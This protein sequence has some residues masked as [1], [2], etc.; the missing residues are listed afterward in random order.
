[1]KQNDK[2][3][4]IVSFLLI[5][6][7][8]II[9][10]GRAFY[11][12]VIGRDELTKRLNKQVLRV[13]K[14]FPYRGSIYDRNG[15]PLAINIQTYT[16]VTIPRLVKDK[17]KTYKKV[18][19][20]V[21]QL[22]Y[23]KI[24]RKIKNR[25][26][27]TFLARKVKLTEEQYLKIKKFEK[28]GIYID[29]V[30]K[31]YYPNN[32]LLA[33]T[34]G[35][36]GSENRGLG[37]IEALFDK[38]LRGKERIIKYIRDAK[39]RPIKFES[40]D[41]EGEAADIHLTI[42]KELQATAEKHLKEAIEKY[43]AT[44]GG[45]GV[46]DSR[47]G[48][49][50]ALA[51]Y[52]TFDPNKYNKSAPEYR[53]LAFVSD[54]F[55][56][57]STF[58][59]LTVASALEHKIARPDTN[60]YCERGAF[61][62]EDH[63]INEAESEKKYEWLSVSEILQFS[64]NIGT[65]KIA[66]DLTYPKLKTTLD[67]F[68]IGKKTKIEIPAESRGIYP[69]GSNVRPLTLSTISFGQGIATTGIQLLAAY[70]AI[71]N[72]G[73]YLPPTVIKGKNTGVEGKR[74]ISKQTAAELTEML[75]KTVEHGT[76]T[77]VKTPYFKIAGK[78]ST[79]QRPASTGGYKGYVPGF[80]GFPLNVDNKFVIYVYVDNPQGN[81]Y[82]GASVAG[83]VFKKVTQYL[84]YKNKDFRKVVV[85]KTKSKKTVS[86][87]RFNKKKIKRS[88]GKGFTPNFLGLDKISSG[89]LAAKHKLKVIHKG[90]GV[91]RE[92]KPKAGTVLKSKKVIK[93]Y[94]RPPTYE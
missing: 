7:F 39:G 32:E 40:Q 56:P 13:S 31:R 53:K 45:I 12:Q 75:V 5:C 92:Q 89:K 71:V 28:N 25:K 64:S 87:N 26:K 34:L 50:L 74:I 51:N 9:I 23:G 1:M 19:S 46:M 43:D 8:F 82:Y 33:Q 62:V 79:A 41:V 54:P 21:P 47:T 69:S 68:G 80:I 84:L 77:L 83:P 86:K 88:F 66:F 29:A 17:Y 72:D 4:I 94:H 65:T 44:M 22:T 18:A 52:P 93:L 38:E 16:I 30:P 37:G 2:I 27:Y 11:I 73:V 6:V 36:V 60:Y 85:D 70:S 55:E 76:A 81:V 15:S 91:V 35:F 49:V 57:G 61:K 90:I 58:K 10:L 63:T 59:T 24:K 3:K 42:D 67:K 14:T 48:E 20:I 78:T